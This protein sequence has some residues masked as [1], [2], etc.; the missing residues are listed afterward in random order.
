MIFFASVIVKYMEK[1]LDMM[2]TC[3]S[4]QILPVP[5][6]CII[7]R[8]HHISIFALYLYFLHVFHYNSSFFTFLIS[9]FLFLK[10]DLLIYDVHVW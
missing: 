1:I 9:V 4:E 10:T 7:L 2:K 5:W 8:F 3:Y 6:H